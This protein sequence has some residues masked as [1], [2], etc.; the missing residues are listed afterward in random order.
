MGVVII[1]RTRDKEGM[2][3]NHGVEQVELWEKME[4][5]VWTDAGTGGVL[6]I[7]KGLERL[8]RRIKVEILVRPGVS[9]VVADPPS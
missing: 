8:E 7:F 6:E 9:T 4:G 3:E 5:I 2:R 1:P